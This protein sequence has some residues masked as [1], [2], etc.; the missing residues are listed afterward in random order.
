M[1]EVSNAGNGV[2]GNITDSAQA[3]RYVEE[4]M[5]ATLVHIA[6]DVKFQV[7][8]NSEQVYAYRLLGY[9]NRAIADEDFRDDLVD[10]GEIGSGHRVTALY[11]VAVSEDALPAATGSPELDDGRAYSGAVEVSA[12]DWVLVKIRYK[13]PGASESDPAKEVSRSLGNDDLLSAL[14]SADADFRWAVAVG[15]FAE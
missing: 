2:Y 4:R 1:E 12:D 15:G 8:F 14:N 13:E 10:A 7:E 9:E 5:L 3:S 11:E 6:K